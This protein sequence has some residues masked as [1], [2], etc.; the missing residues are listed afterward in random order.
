MKKFDH[1]AY[2]S[3]LRATDASL[4][5]VAETLAALDEVEIK[6]VMFEN[7]CDAVLLVVP[8]HYR[9]GGFIFHDTKNRFNDGDLITTSNVVN[10]RPVSPYSVIETRNTTY[11]CI[12]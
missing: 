8:G 6:N 7:N 4:D 3:A 1:R 11:L 9:L 2:V 12:G 5:V 10:A